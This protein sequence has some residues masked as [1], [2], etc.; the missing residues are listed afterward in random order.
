M[1]RHILI[2]ERFNEYSQELKL[3]GTPSD[4]ACSAES[5][6]AR[7]TEL[8]VLDV[9]G[10]GYEDSFKVD[11]IPSKFEENYSIEKENLLGDVKK[12]YGGEY[13]L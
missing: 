6:N 9:V 13:E 11:F 12:R 5:L 7:A 8:E 4:T 10:S 1:E 3:K 2:L